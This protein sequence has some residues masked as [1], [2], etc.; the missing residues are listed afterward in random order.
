MTEV[1]T[2]RLVF[3]GG[4]HRS[5]TTALGRILADHP[6]ISGFADTGV[7][8]DEGQHLQDVYEPASSYGGP[9][10]FARRD[11]AHLGPAPESVRR[12]HRERLLAAW[13]PYWDLDRSLLVE[14]SPPNLIMGRYLQSVFPGSALVVIVR[15]PVVVALSTEKWRPNSRLPRLIRHWFVAHDRLRAD[16]PSLPRLHVVRYEDLIDRPGPTLTD[17]GRFLGLRSPLESDILEGSRSSA[18]IDRWDAMATGEEADRETRRRIIA[19]L[20]G[21]AAEYGYDLEDLT[22]VGPSCLTPDPTS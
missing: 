8:E 9:G 13:A 20:S 15:N 6:D 1:D 18:Y 7:P 21:R 14:K 11:E 4:L 10:R 5:G 12:E 3:V 22:A 17:L 19:R 2:S 16:A